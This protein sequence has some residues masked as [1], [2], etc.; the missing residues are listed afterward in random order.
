M[1]RQSQDRHQEA[2]TGQE[3]V[4]FHESGSLSNATEIS[5][6]VP[7]SDSISRDT[8]KASSRSCATTIGNQRSGA[9][10]SACNHS[11][12]LTRTRCGQETIAFI[13]L[14]EEVKRLKYLRQ[15]KAKHNHQSICGFSIF[16]LT[17]CL[18]AVVSILCGVRS[19]GGN[20]SAIPR[21]LP[22]S[23]I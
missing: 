23:R 15:S 1:S 13:L 16:Q 4:H 3:R 10:S 21:I 11:H 19:F 20:F 12:C 7:Y 18:I 22:H 8:A 6:R 2:G 9:V 14:R 5:S 17:S